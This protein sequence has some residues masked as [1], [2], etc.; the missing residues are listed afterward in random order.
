MG[1][2]KK[3]EEK[4]APEGQEIKHVDTKEGEELLKC[5]LTDE[6]LLAYG[7]QL[8]DA[9]NDMVEIEGE[10]KEFKANIKGRKETAQATS[11]RL[12]R[13]LRAGYEHRH[14]VVTTVFDYDDGT[15]TKTRKDTEEEFETRAMTEAEKQRH[16]DL[17]GNGDPVEPKIL[18]QA[19][20]L[21]IEKQRATTGTIQRGLQIGY[22]QAAQILDTLEAE[23][24]VGPPRGSE[25][26]EIFGEQEPEEEGTQEEE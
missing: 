13:L 14:V 4:Q 5:D 21:I 10:E 19:K 1:K 7:R 20:E 12:T 2:K 16:L 25:P 11:D 3:E 23:G 15:V 22:T 26:R 6:E 17:E 9:Q 8:A 18:E 24:F